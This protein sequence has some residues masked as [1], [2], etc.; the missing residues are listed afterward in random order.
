VCKIRLRNNQDSNQFLFFIYEEKGEGLRGFENKQIHEEMKQE[1]DFD[2]D[3]KKK[4]GE[5]GERDVCSCGALLLF[6]SVNQICISYMECC[7]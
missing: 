6:L 2:R 3:R 4:G 5:K 7:P 1:T